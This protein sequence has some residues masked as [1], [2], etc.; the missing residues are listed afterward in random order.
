M[1]HFLCTHFARGARSARMTRRATGISPS[2]RTGFGKSTS[3]RRSR[4]RAS[5]LIRQAGD[6]YEENK[7]AYYDLFHTLTGPKLPLDQLSDISRRLLDALERPCLA[8][9]DTETWSPLPPA[10]GMKVAGEEPE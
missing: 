3:L 5:E 6:L 1:H 2:I 10:R 7:L 4:P 8:A 9:T